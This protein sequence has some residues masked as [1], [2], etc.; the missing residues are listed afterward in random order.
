MSSLE[1]VVAALKAQAGTGDKGAFAQLYDAT[2]AR[3]FGTI[4]RI[5]ADQGQ[6]ED[7]LQEVYVKIWQGAASFRPELGS[8][9]GW[10][11]TIARNQAIDVRRRAAER[12]SS[13]SEELDDNLP[14]VSA[15]GSHPAEQFEAVDR[16]KKCLEGLPADR[17]QMIVLAYHQ[18]WS[19][20]ELS[21]Q[22][23]RPVT[24][25]KTILRRSL[26]ALRECLDAA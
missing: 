5:L 7:A 19:R 4:R 3:L 14:E 18:G 11:L 16:L 26:M 8:A 2:A 1:Q 17:Q 20:D 24:T 10:M 25:I 6:A 9:I 12:I 23:H 15:G 21:R 13:H 22:F